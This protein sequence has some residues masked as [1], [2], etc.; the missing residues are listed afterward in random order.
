M[1]ERSSMHEVTEARQL[2]TSPL[3]VLSVAHGGVLHG[4]GRMRYEALSRQAGLELTL[5]VPD[6]WREYGV[7][8]RAEP[9][10][11][12]VKVV[13]APVRWLEAGPAKWYLHHYKSLSQILREARPDVIHL[14]EEPWSFVAWQ[15]LRLRDRLLPDAALVL[16]TD[17][18]ILRRLPPPF[19]QIRR[20]T[21]RHTD[22]LVARQAEAEAVSRACGFTGAARYVGY[23]V[24]PKIF[25][26][27]STS[28]LVESRPRQVL[29]LGY[30]GRIVRAKGIFDIL[31]ALAATSGDVQFTLMG[32]GPDLA[33]FEAR[34]HALGLSGR[35]RV[36]D[37]QP[38]AQVADLMRS[39]D[40][41]LLMSRTTKSWKEQFGRVI[42]EAQAC[43]TPVIGSS[44]GAIP[45]VVCAGGWII[46]EG[47]VA[48][49]A[50]LFARL[51]RDRAEQGGVLRNGAG[52][53]GLANVARRYTYAKVGE[54]LLDA[55]R[56]AA[57]VR[58]PHR[59][60]GSSEVAASHTGSATAPRIMVVHET[61]GRKHLEAHGPVASERQIASAFFHAALLLRHVAQAVMRDRK[62]L[63]HALEMTLDTLRFRFRIGL[64]LDPAV[65]IGLA[66]RD[67]STSM[68]RM[69]IAPRRYAMTSVSRQCRNILFPI[70]G[71]LN[72][73]SS[74]RSNQSPLELIRTTRQPGKYS[75]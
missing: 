70:V 67:V 60:A 53:L 30:V 43:G 18:N 10:A 50:G 25:Y 72:E 32:T 27:K 44:S 2:N 1:I 71:P 38:P 14:W 33:E 35:V 31:D 46:P 15:A 5:V 6:R 73:A 68:S 65:I 52:A 39:I 49:L 61:D 24:D 48:A 74:T 34:S 41:L 23:G 26:P 7:T 19:E 12:D 55:Y 69:A 64:E 45:E 59:F 20:L 57:A 36:V 13:A 17:Q 58:V 75:C 47:D 54:Q 66:P 37:P 51:R 3:R 63:R 11:G 28:Q 22:L 29:T 42:I 40:A 8:Y 56:T 21:L 9:Q 16:E 62:A 4:M